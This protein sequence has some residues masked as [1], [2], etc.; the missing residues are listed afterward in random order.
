M[1][2]KEENLDLLIIKCQKEKRTEGGMLGLTEECQKI[3]NYV[4]RQA[5]G[6]SSFFNYK[7]SRYQFI[8]LPWTHFAQ[9]QEVPDK[10]FLCHIF[11]QVQND[12]HSI[13]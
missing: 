2:E 8:Y 3:W 7:L 9:T 12:I 11:T 1:L 10:G 6:I 5:H 13:F 4:P